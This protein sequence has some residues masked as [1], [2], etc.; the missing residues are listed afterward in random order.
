MIRRATGGS[1]L[2]TAVLVL[3]AVYCLL[4]VL[5]VPIA[6]TKDRSQLFQTFT[7]MPSL[8]HG[9]WTNLQELDAYR[10]GIFWHWLANSALYAGLGSL[11]STA[12]SALTG[13]TLAKLRFRGRELAFNLILAGVLVPGVILAIPQYFL[14]ARVGLAGSYLSVLLPSVLS[15][16]GI[17]LGRIYA[18][19]AVPDALLEAA[20][21]DGAS[22]WRIYR[23]VALP[24]MLPGLVTILLFQFVAI[25]NNFLLPFIML[26]D[27]HRFPVTVGLYA[28]LN[29]GASI[30]ALY[31][32]VITGA[33][34][35]IIPIIALFLS[36]QR[37]WRID[38]VSGAVRG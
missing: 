19:A 33:L 34:L 16:Y 13:Y 1:V 26:S 17:Y 22:E 4:P 21:I 20:R 10:G 30:P 27:D 35:S 11:L 23:S 37:F 7:L 25:W 18:S 24:L 29:Q 8:G 28:L 36:L 15:P 14:L 31:T 5:W 9:L 3:G 32:V 12:L 2:G 38:L 6:A